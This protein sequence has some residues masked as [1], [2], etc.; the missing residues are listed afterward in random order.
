MAGKFEPSEI[1]LATVAGSDLKVLKGDLKFTAE[2]GTVWTAPDGTLTD[3]ASVPRLMLAV[4]DGRFDNRFLK[5]R[6]INFFNRDKTLDQVSENELR[7]R[8]LTTGNLGGFDAWL[9]DPYAGTLKLETAPVKCGV[10]V[11]EIGLE[12]ETVE[13]GALDRRVRIFRLPEDN[14]HRRMSLER[15][16]ALRP[17]G[18]NPLYVR[19][20]QEDGHLAWSS[21]IYVFR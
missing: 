19:I 7:W 18:D 11:E 21:P 5:A 4:T 6:P 3:G 16:V 1:S 13:A 14:P 15:R 12:D 17:E 9:A 20:T 2:D 10:P 8:A